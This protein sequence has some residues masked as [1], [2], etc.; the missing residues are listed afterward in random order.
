MITHVGPAVRRV[1]PA[2]AVALLA[3]TLAACNLLGAGYQLDQERVQARAALQRWDAAAAAAG[4]QAL[5]VVGDQTGQIGDWEEAVGDNKEALIAGKVETAVALP[6]DTPPPADI[7][8]DNGSVRTLPMISASQALRDIQA[9]GAQACPTCDPLAIIGAALTSVEIETNGGPARAP[10]W[11]FALRGTAVHLTRVAVAAGAKITVVPPAWDPNHAPV[12]LSIESASGSASS[13]G[14]TVT[15]TGAPGPR[16]EPCGADYTGEAVESSTAI[17]VIVI[18][19]SNPLPVVCAAV[20][21]MRTATVHLA[22]PLGDRAVLEVQ[23]G[24]PVPVTL[25]PTP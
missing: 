19:S 24:L 9:A 22:S 5:V 25:T 15:F 8:W 1:T 16:S 13:Q 6:T 4:D 23:Q 10:A 7:R 14:L 20:G 12:G 17:V 21:A 11:D 2:L 18:E 3:A